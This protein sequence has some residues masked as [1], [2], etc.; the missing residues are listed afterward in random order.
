MAAPWMGTRARTTRSHICPGW[1]RGVRCL[2]TITTSHQRTTK[3]T[4]TSFQLTTNSTFLSL[5][6]PVSR[7]HG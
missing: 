3:T 4:T 2:L 6:G 1:N 5:T 7:S